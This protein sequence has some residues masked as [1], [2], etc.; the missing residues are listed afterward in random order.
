MHPAPLHETIL[1]GKKMVIPDKTAIQKNIPVDKY[2]VIP[3]T[4]FNPV[5]PGFS[6]P[7]PFI[8]L[9]H[10][11]QRN[12]KSKSFLIDQLPRIVSASIIG[13]NDLVRQHNLAPDA[14][15]Y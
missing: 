14:I 15:K 9:P 6:S 4:H 3:G 8:F 13:N 11:Q 12:R 2:N 5:I 10:M 7:K 1:T